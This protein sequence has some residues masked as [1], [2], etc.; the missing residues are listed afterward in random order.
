MGAGVFWTKRMKCRR[1]ELSRSHGNRDTETEK[2]RKVTQ[3]KILKAQTQA[4]REVFDFIADLGVDKVKVLEI[5]RQVLTEERWGAELVVGSAASILSVD[6]TLILPPP[7]ML[8]ELERVQSAEYASWLLAQPEPRP[9][10]LKQILNSYKNG[11]AEYRK[12]LLEAGNVLPVRKSDGRK[13][14]I[15]DPL[16]RK[17]IRDEIKRRYEPGVTLIRIFRALAANYDVHWTNIK[18]IWY[19][20]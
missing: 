10:V 1:T 5:S 11:L 7:Q 3:Q 4:L 15:S 14:S 12:Q 2:L 8:N 9:E 19:Q 6:R 20:G 18:R 17:H 13:P 16:V